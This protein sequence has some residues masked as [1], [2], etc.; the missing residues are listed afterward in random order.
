MYLGCNVANLQSPVSQNRQNNQH[1]TD[2]LLTISK[3]AFL[4]NTVPQGA[5]PLVLLRVNLMTVPMVSV[6]FL[7]FVIAFYYLTVSD[8]FNL[9][10]SK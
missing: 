10:I 3:Q 4:A 8:I 5:M 2:F 9:P 7:L 1:Q 6:H